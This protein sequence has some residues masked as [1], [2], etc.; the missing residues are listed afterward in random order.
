MCKTIQTDVLPK[1][2]YPVSLAKTKEKSLFGP[3]LCHILLPMI[4]P[5]ILIHFGIKNQTSVIQKVVLF[6]GN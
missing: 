4:L 5:P 2:T 6:F 1:F 3:E